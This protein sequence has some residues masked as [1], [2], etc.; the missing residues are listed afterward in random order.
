MGFY[1]C[2]NHC[3]L[4]DIFILLVLSHIFQ[5]K[6]KDGALD[7]EL[8]GGALKVGAQAPEELFESVL[9]KLSYYRF[10]KAQTVAGM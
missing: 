2:L 10:G 4:S 9:Y 7:D 1:M 8:V 5:R 6:Q 3:L